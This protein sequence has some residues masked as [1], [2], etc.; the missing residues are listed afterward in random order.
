[1]ILKVYNVNVEAVSYL[2]FEAGF[3]LNSTATEK[4]KR[5]FAFAAK[6]KRKISLEKAL[7]DWIP[8]R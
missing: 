8:L 5:A 6:E 4:N 1:M 3:M 7:V 2:F